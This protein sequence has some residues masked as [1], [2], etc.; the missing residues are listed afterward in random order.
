MYVGEVK[1]SRL[2]KIGLSLYTFFYAAKH[3]YCFQDGSTMIIEAAKGGHTNVVKL[4][5]EWPNR[6]MLNSSIDLAQPD[7]PHVNMAQAA[8]EEVRHPK[9]HFTDVLGLMI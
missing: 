4:L 8:L 9:A 3:T 6:L 7:M 2:S 1:A 5:L